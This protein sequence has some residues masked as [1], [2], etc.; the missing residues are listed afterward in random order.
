MTSSIQLVIF[1]IA[2]TLIEDH[3]EV[4]DSFLAALRSNGIDATEGEIK[5]WK[6]SSK[7]EV[8]GHFV[9]RQHGSCR[10]GPLI[11][12]AYANFRFLIE[13]RYAEGGVVPITGAS[14]TLRW[15]CERRIKI[16]TTTGFYREL[17]DAI[18]RAAGWEQ[19]FDANLCSDDVLHGR[20]A[21]DMILRAMELSGVSDPDH[22]LNVGDTPLDLQSAANAKVGISVG[23]LSGRHTRARLLREPHH[24][25]IESVADLP[26]LLAT[27]TGT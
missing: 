23:V 27:L 4:T 18:L 10:I 5:E 14:E 2:G 25:L 9:A 19:T 11:E 15:L 21:P 8:I 16:V 12:Q 1:D 26:R 6:G 24:H 20:P 22:V 17:R 13:K 3:D 7:R